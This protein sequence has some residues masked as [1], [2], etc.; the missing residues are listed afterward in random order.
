[1]G[2]SAL[3]P[4]ATAKAVPPNGQ[5]RTAPESRRVRRNRHVCFGPMVDIEIRPYQLS[6]FCLRCFGAIFRAG[7]AHIVL[8]GPVR[9][10]QR[11]PESLPDL[12]CVLLQMF[13][14]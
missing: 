4:L 3:P 5:V 13:S 11:T 2:T 1:M 12:G 6:G 8:L 7:A 14:D 9:I 10:A